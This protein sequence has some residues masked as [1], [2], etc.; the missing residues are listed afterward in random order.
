MKIL[1]IV[2]ARPYFIKIAP[3]I[4]A[5]NHYPDRIDQMLVHTG[6][7]YYEKISNAFFDDL[8][9]PKPDID[10][11]VGSGTHAEQTARIMVEFEK[12]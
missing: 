8:G 5:M 6:Q 10:L 7:H 12:V 9:M 1:N 2:G 4:E 3:I 11:V